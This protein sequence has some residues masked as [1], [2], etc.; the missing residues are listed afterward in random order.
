MKDDKYNIYIQQYVLFPGGVELPANWT[1]MFST[2]HESRVDL[3]E[4]SEE[5]KRVL[6]KV[7]DSID[8][9]AKGYFFEVSM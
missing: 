9:S 8:I 1:G 2:T 5:Y 6:K 7:K 4:K 3:D